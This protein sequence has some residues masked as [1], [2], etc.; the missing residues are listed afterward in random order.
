MINNLIN[1]VKTV[2]HT[3][4]KEDVVKN[5]DDIT[6]AIKEEVIPTLDV[7]IKNSDLEVINK[8]K[9]V[10]SLMITSDIKAKDGRDL[11]VKIKGIFVN[12]NKSL[13]NLE[14]LVVD[15]LPDIVSDKTITVKDAAILKTISDIGNMALYASDFAYF[16]IIDG[17]PN[18]TEFPKKKINDILH[19]LPTYGSML[20]IYGNNF[21]KTIENIK[22][23][24]D[25]K[26]T[27]DNKKANMLEKI[28]SK[29]AKL[30]DTPIASGFNYNPIYHVRMWLVDVEMLK[31][32][33][34]KDKKKLIELKLM[35]LKLK[36]KNESNDK[37]TKQIEYYEEK[38]AK[39]E[40]KISKIEGK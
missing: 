21:N 4:K 26:L 13:S 30:V 17:D 19:N 36:A 39:I 27:L 15:E 12:I 40:Y 20:K 6:T 29:D 25:I 8:S 23:L 38:L 11:F 2:F 14:T 35:E 37:L 5:L 34:L 16:V 7:V 24:P 18:N 3:I 10:K 22:K 31:Y 32:E 1:Y 33:R 28:V 9:Y